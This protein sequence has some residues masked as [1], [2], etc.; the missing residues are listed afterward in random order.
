MAALSRSFTLPTYPFTPAGFFVFRTP[1]LPFGE[2]LAWGDGLAAKDSPGALE[3]ALNAD[4]R[5]LRSRLKDQLSSPIIREALFLASPSLDES[6]PFWLA[7][8]D[9]P[10]GKKVE[11]TLVRYF[12]RMTARPTPFGLFAG[13]SLGQIGDQTQLELASRKEYTRHTRLDMDYLFANTAA[14][15]QDPELLK[16]LRYFP[17]SSLY[18]AAQR[19]RYY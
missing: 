9:S 13:C 14:L 16:S 5:L 1:L 18:Q 7:D 2:L 15:A 17:N 19:L 6:L 4:R 3:S 8:P 12:Q 10:R 11:R